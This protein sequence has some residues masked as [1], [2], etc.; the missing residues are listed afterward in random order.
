MP[1]AVQKAEQRRINTRQ[2]G[3]VIPL[4]QGLAA[5]TI[6]GASGGKTALVITT[7]KAVTIGKYMPSGIPSTANVYVPQT[8]LR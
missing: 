7:G 3:A 1:R 8:L 2:A 5:L 6:N 4:R